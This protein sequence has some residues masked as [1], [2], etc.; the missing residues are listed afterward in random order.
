MSKKFIPLNAFPTSL[1][2][3]VKLLANA[4]GVLKD[5][6]VR[7]DRSGEKSLRVLVTNGMV[8]AEC[9][10]STG[11]AFEFPSE[12]QVYKAGDFKRLLAKPWFTTNRLGYLEH[13]PSGAKDPAAVPPG[14]AG[15]FPDEWSVL[16]TV[17]GEPV[18]SS[19]VYLERLAPALVA[20]EEV[21][22]DADPDDV[23]TPMILEFR[24]G[25]IVGDSRPL[26]PVHRAVY[27]S[28]T[29]E[30]GARRVSVRGIVL[31]AQKK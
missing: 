15:K 18:A 24:E 31:G 8:L 5:Y 9:V 17:K 29:S 19:P 16:L 6:V 10:M 26:A 27:F 22:R 21:L 25:N 11:Q 23:Y 20:A 2:A 12:P 30:C 1:L 28:Q 14:A 3:F 4:P 13:H 7:V